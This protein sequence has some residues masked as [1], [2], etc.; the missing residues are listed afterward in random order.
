MN[1]DIGEVF[2]RHVV[3]CVVLNRWSIWKFG[4]RYRI[5]ISFLQYEQPDVVKG[6]KIGDK[7]CRKYHTD[8]V[9]LRCELSG[10]FQDE[11][12]TTRIKT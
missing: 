7:L 10:E 12:S 1:K 5:E 3:V 9:F 6:V 8:T 11:S 4:H 2:L